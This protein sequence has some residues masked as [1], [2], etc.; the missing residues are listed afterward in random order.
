VVTGAS[1]DEGAGEGFDEDGVLAD[2]VDE[3]IGF[4][5]DFWH[6]RRSANVTTTMRMNDRAC[7]LIIGFFPLQ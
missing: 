5:A 1:V 2:G 6:P 3:V 4:G 7:R